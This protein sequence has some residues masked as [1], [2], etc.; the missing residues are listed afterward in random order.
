[1]VVSLAAVRCGYPDSTR[2]VFFFNN[3][4]FLG[5]VKTKRVREVFLSN[6]NEIRSVGISLGGK[7]LYFSLYSSESDIWLM[8]LE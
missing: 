1:L 7:L 2:F 8:D 4:L 6:E 3:K 5:D